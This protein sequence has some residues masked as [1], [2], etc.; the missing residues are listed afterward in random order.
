LI[1][2]KIKGLVEELSSCNI[3]C[4][5]NANWL[6]FE[7]L[8][9]SL[10]QHNMDELDVFDS[11]LDEIVRIINKKSQNHLTRHRKEEMN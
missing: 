3:E 6:N 2:K 4:L 9:N 11:I 8:R 10:V 1:Q 7:Y 5:D